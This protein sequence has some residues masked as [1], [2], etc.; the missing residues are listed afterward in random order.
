MLVISACL[1]AGF[2]SAVSSAV[3]A[4]AGTSAPATPSADD[5]KQRERELEAVREQQKNAVELQERLKVDIAAIGR[6]RAKLNQQLI[7]VAA[8]VRDIET[9]IAEAEAR[10][11][12]LGAREQDIR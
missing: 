1:L 6:N 4:Q 8:R 3:M 5:I 9:S 2:S 11:L 10:L 12:P 7:D